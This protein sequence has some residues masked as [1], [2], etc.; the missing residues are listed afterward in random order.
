MIQ[1]PFVMI[2][3]E[4]MTALA[5]LDLREMDWFVKVSNFFNLEIMHIF[6]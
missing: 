4:A 3:L 5:I 2:L 6:Y 1:I